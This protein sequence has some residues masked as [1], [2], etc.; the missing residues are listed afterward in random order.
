M[1]VNKNTPASFGY[2]NADKFETMQNALA[3]S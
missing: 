1:E 2:D 3:I